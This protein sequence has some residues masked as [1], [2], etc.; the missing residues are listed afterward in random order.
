MDGGSTKREPCS[1]TRQYSDSSAAS[2]VT[3]ALLQAAVC[4]RASLAEGLHLSIPPLFLS[5]LAIAASIFSFAAFL[6]A[7]FNCVSSFAAA[8][9]QPPFPLRHTDTAR[10]SSGLGFVGKEHW[11]YTVF[12]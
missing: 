6:P 10:Q 1:E 2:P 12:L 3:E 5:R 11:A 7:V 8:S 9:P 4:V